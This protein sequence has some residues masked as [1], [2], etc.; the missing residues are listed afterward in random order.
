MLTHLYLAYAKISDGD[1]EDKDKR[2]SADYNVNHPMEVLIQQI[3]NFVDIV[4]ASDNLYSAEQ[5][6]TDAY[7]LVLKTG[8]F[9]DNRKMWRRR[10]PAYKT[11]PHLKTY[12]TV[13]HQELR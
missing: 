2:M 1:Q 5:V 8:M 9:P 6:V 10:D 4:A 12:F 3:V 11:W 13:A 7:N